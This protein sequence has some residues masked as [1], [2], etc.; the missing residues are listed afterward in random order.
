MNETKRGE[1]TKKNFGKFYGL[2]Q[3]MERR[4]ILHGGGWEGRQTMSA[5][6]C[7]HSSKK[8]APIRKKT[9]KQKNSWLIGGKQK[10]EIGRGKRNLLQQKKR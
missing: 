9:K 1:A 4:T 8:R 2:S 3:K 5:Q 7:W 10:G 6:N